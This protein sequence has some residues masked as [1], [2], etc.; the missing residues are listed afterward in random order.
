MGATFA[1]SGWTGKLAGCADV[2]RWVHQDYARAGLLA[3]T[4]QAYG[5]SLPALNETYFLGPADL[6]S[7]AD[8]PL[9]TVGAHSASHSALS[10]LYPDAARRELVENRSYLESLLGRPV[11]HLAYPYGNSRA[12]GEREFALANELLFQSAVTTSQGPLFSLHRRTPH[13]LPRV[14]VS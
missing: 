8:H 14:G 9:V 6:R 10:I 3:D 4:F 1:C 11:A 2:R 5:I 13:S 7:L 12:C